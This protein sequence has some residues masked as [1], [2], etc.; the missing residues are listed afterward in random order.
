MF[1]HEGKVVERRADGAVIRFSRDRCGQCRGCAAPS[2]TSLL[3]DS[4]GSDSE[5]VRVSL[6][7]PALR[8]ILLN[9]LGWPLFGFVLAGVLA[10]ILGLSDA[11]AAALCLAGLIAGIFSCRT[12][13]RDTLSIK[14]VFHE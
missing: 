10:A 7:A 6:S 3:V 9:S 4:V 11:V 2:A 8:S 14:E 13:D 12:L 5:K 1:Q